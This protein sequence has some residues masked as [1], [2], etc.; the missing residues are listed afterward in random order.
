MRGGNIVKRVVSRRRSIIKA[1]TYRIFIMILDFLTI[2]IL[3]GTTR[4]AVGFMIVSNIYTT[5]A[6]V[7]HER[8]WA[9]V[10]WGI[11]ESD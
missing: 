3:T 11:D 8:L 7:L 2:Y 4:V 1:G 6:Y 10:N 5:I 9:R